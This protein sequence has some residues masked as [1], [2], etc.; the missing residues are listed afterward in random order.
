MD[1]EYLELVDEDNNPMGLK[2]LRSEVH[3]DGDWHRTVHVHFFRKNAGILEVLAHLRSK[4]K[5]SVPNTWDPR[6]G[7]H[8]GYGSSPEETVVEEIRDE[9]GLNLSV[10]DLIE[11]RWYKVEDAREFTLVYFYNY[12]GSIHDLRFNDNEVQK[13]RWISIQ[14]M[15]DEIH[16]NPNMWCCSNVPPGREYIFD[17]MEELQKRFA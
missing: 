10:Q 4:D 2:K 15:V 1:L 6:F 16:Q 7:G 17:S 11:W 5:D 12:E 3:R 9:V 8:I 14:D 13:V